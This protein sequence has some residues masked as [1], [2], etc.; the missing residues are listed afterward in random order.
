[1]LHLSFTHASDDLPCAE[2]CLIITKNDIPICSFTTDYHA[3]FF[4]S[5]GLVSFHAMSSDYPGLVSNL[6]RGILLNPTCNPPSP[7]CVG[8]LL[9]LISKI[10]KFTFLIIVFM[11][12]HWRIVYKFWWLN[13]NVWFNVDI[14]SILG[15]RSVAWFNACEIEMSYWIIIATGNDI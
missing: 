10:L 6:S 9:R 11:S 8:L 1:M 14:S 7:T 3:Q 12:T 13:Q 2:L 5:S 4:G 15:N